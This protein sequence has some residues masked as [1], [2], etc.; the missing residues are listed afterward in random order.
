MVKLKNV[1]QRYILQQFQDGIDFLLHNA[2]LSIYTKIAPSILI[3][4]TL[5]RKRIK[6]NFKGML[7]RR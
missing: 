4:Y 2:G 7:F 3:T 6:T 1:A 5:S